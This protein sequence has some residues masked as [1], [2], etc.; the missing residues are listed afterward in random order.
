MQFLIILLASV[1]LL[2]LILM[3]LSLKSLLNRNKSNNI[4]SCGL[5]SSEEPGCGCSNVENCYHKKA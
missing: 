4:T 5:S 1:I 3:G 2:A